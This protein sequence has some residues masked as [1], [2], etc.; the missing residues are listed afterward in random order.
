MIRVSP[1]P[2]PKDFDARVRQKGLSA[3][4]E[5]IGRPPRL[6]RPGPR[7]KPV[8]RQ[9]R[10]IPPDAFP[11]LWRDSIPALRKAYDGR[12]A[13][14][15]M[16]IE[17]ATGASTVDHFVPKS[18]DWRQVYEW[19]NYRLC[20][21]GINGTKGDRPLLDPFEVEEGW[22]EL[23]LVSFQVVLGPKAPAGR[24]KEIRA[25]LRDSGINARECC[26]LRG[27]YVQAFEQ[28]E[29]SLSYLERRAPFVAAALRRA[30]RID[31]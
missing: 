21:G 13:Y 28:N 23:E 25:T 22:F 9:R 11:P 24:H 5:L 8:A 15:A 14:L 12:C 26:E 29:I 7:R 4:D 19:S 1:A 17:P 6:K 10:H 31:D 18:Q 2:E 16:F 30:G 20:A 27:Q 3:I